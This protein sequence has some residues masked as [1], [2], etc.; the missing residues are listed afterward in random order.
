MMLN[1]DVSDVEVFP[2]FRQG[3]D[4]IFLMTGDPITGFNPNEGD[5]YTLFG[6]IATLHKVVALSSITDNSGGYVTDNLGGS[7]NAPNIIGQYVVDDNGNFV[8][9]DNGN[10][11]PAL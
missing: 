10:K 6:G 5:Y 8:L 7:I 3:L 4:F 1:L 2:S 9:D 11:I